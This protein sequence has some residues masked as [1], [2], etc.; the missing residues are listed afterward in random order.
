MSKP[1]PFVTRLE[2][3]PLETWSDARGRLSFHTLVSGDRTPS[4][5]LVA[6]VAIVAPGGELA[7]H[8]HT[9]PEI[10][11]AL[12]GKAVVTIDGVAHDV[13]A[14]AAVFIPGDA[15]HGISNPFGETFRIF[16]VFPADRFEEIRYR[17]AGGG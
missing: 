1:Q 6:G 5:G 16:Y 14:G 10:Y 4:E 11:F 3:A 15:P 9:Q 2:D 8:S 7:L 12:E 17:F 13:A